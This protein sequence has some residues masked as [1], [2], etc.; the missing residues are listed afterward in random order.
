MDFPIIITAFIVGAF[1]GVV[2]HMWFTKKPAEDQLQ[3]Q[4][5]QAKIDFEQ[6]QEEFLDYVSQSHQGLEK[7][8]EAI[9]HAN[10]QW[11]QSTQNLVGEK[12]NK[13][14]M[15]FNYIETLMKSGNIT[16]KDY[17]QDAEKDI[18]PS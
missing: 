13:Q 18:M 1:F 5:D 11:N 14:L 16:P 15:T 7:V 8:T 17:P 2:G 12:F 6:Q 10:Q 9:N 3:Q 4:L